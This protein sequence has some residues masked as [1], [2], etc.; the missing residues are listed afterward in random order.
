MHYALI[1]LDFSQ[2]ENFKNFLKIGIA[3]FRSLVYI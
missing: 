1:T 2:N 3:R